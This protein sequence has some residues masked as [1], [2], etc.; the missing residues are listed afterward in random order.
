VNVKDLESEPGARGET[1]PPE[2]LNETIEWQDSPGGE[3]SES[4]VAVL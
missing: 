1:E 2:V 4:R 3:F